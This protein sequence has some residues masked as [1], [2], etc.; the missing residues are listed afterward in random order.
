MEP[1]PFTPGTC[2]TQPQNLRRLP[3]RN[4]LHLPFVPYPCSQYRFCHTWRTLLS[5]RFFV[6]CFWRR[7][8]HSWR[9]SRHSWRRSRC[10][11]SRSRHSWRRSRCIGAGL[12]IDGAGL[13]VIGAGPKIASE[14]APY[15]G[16]SRLPVA[17]VS[18]TK[19]NLLRSPPE[20]APFTPGT[21]TTQ[22]QNL[23]RSPPEP[24][25]LTPVTCA[26][27]PGTCA[28]HPQNHPS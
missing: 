21:C 20:P 11:W 5:L 28:T 17:Q 3:P 18:P 4:L 14:P 7:S 9:R 15:F 22:P 24:A 13:V 10:N 26:A 2:S 16:F 23:R 6:V 25:P 27:H 12:D 1:A 8:R 19:W